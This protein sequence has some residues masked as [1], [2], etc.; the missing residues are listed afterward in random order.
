MMGL[1]INMHTMIL[2]PF[3]WAVYPQVRWSGAAEC[4]W[5]VGVLE[6]RH[7]HQLLECRHSP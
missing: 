4:G 3:Q 1:T 5:S 2:G 6:G 7:S